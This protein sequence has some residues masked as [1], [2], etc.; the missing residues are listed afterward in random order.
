MCVP[1]PLK[2]TGDLR[3]TPMDIGGGV[4]YARHAMPCANVLPFWLEAI[5]LRVTRIPCLP[6]AAVAVSVVLAASCIGAVAAA[7]RSERSAPT[8]SPAL[9]IDVNRTGKTS[10]LPL[11]APEAAHPVLVQDITGAATTVVAKGER[12][13]KVKARPAA[14]P[15]TMPRG[16]LSS[17]GGASASAMQENMTVCLADA[18]GI[19]D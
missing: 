11:G 14:N 3:Q 7:Q 1:E 19:R 8:A 2:V 6:G 17:I 5:M 15:A 16:C 18:S 10:R 4:T 12:V 9:Q 13:V